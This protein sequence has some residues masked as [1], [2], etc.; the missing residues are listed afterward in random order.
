VLQAPQLL[1]LLLQQQLLA[2]HQGPSHVAGLSLVLATRP[3]EAEALLRA[4]EL[5]LL[6]AS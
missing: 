4:L 2:L 6:S 5:E 3:A 1:L